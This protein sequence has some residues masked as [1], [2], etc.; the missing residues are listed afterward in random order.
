MQRSFGFILL[1]LLN[2]GTLAQIEPTNCTE[3]FN[4]S[5]TLDELLGQ[6]RD[7]DIRHNLTKASEVFWTHPDLTIEYIY[8][9]LNHEDW[10]VCQ[11]ICQQIW[12]RIGGIRDPRLSGYTIT[13][14]TPCPPP[15]PNKAASSPCSS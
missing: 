14:K 11:I 1:A 2:T 13:S 9:P 12:Y 6:F 8:N 15:T 10:Q 3:T 5:Y 7:D 4:Y